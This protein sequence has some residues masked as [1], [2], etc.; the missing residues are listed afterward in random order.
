MA[1]WGRR[2]SPCEALRD[3][4]RQL[5]LPLGVPVGV[6]GDRREVV[7]AHRFD[8]DRDASLADTGERD[9]RT[10]THVPE[11]VLTFARAGAS[12]SAVR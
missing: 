10:T 2:R 1:G 4:L 8:R 6:C 11:R 5:S 3:Q 12:P 7:R 9:P